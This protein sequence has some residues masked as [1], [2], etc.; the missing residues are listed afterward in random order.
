MVVFLMKTAE[1]TGLSLSCA[2][3]SYLMDHVRRYLTSYLLTCVLL[4]LNKLLTPSTS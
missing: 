1:P 4:I 3:P 2:S